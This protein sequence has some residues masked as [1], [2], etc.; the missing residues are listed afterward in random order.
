MD[1]H[2]EDA[3]EAEVSRT[4][5][6]SRSRATRETTQTSTGSS[7]EAAAAQE[8][9]LWKRMMA[10]FN[11]RGATLN[12]LPDTLVEEISELRDKN[13]PRRRLRGK[14]RASGAG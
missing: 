9:D 7:T 14:Q 8:D 13:E 11:V 2:N 5:P 3:R 10:V 1:H 4:G 6:G 12:D